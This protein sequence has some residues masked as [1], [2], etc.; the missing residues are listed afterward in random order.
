MAFEVGKRVVA[1]SESTDPRARAPVSLRKCWEESLA[2]LP[3][4]L[5]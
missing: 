2:S 3:H 5:G 4:S 1:E